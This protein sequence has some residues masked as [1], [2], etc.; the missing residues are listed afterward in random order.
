MSFALMASVWG[1][2]QRQQIA[3][4]LSARSE[5]T[6]NLPKGSSLTEIAEEVQQFYLRDISQDEG[7]VQEFV[8]ERA[9]IDWNF[10]CAVLRVSLRHQSV[11]RQ[12]ARSYCWLPFLVPAI[13]KYFS[14]L[15]D[16]IG[17]LVD[18]IRFV[19]VAKPEL[20]LGLAED[21]EAVVWT[22]RISPRAHLR[23]MWNL[24][25]SAILHPLSNTTI[26]LST[27]RVLYRT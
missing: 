6:H 22:V 5:S 12:W 27:G 25:W 19:L 24:F 17:A 13:R 21:L 8:L 7:V 2:E 26:D 9:R 16:G 10:T 20:E 11:L 15:N 3:R 18:L 4:L 14:E 1:D 23:A